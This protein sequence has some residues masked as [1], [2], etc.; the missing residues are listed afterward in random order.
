MPL[1]NAPTGSHECR[2]RHLL[3]QVGAQRAVGRGVRLGRRPEG[4]GDLLH[5]ATAQPAQ[6]APIKV[7]SR[8]RRDQHFKRCRSEPGCRHSRRH[9]GHD[10]AVGL[11][12][13]RRPTSRRAPMQWA[14]GRLVVNWRKL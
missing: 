8:V 12:A 13:D 2:G 4:K 6:D 10:A 7:K 3:A 11:R 9:L 14:R 1:S 5:L